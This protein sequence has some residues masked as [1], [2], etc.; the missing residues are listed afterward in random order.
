M[1]ILLAI[2]IGFILGAAAL[3]WGGG[4][5]GA[6]AGAILMHAWRS[7]RETRDAGEYSLPR[8]DTPPGAAAAVP[9]VR[10]TVEERLAAI[11][12]RLEALERGGVASA[13]SPAQASDR[14]PAAVPGIEPAGSPD[15]SALPAAAAAP[16]IAWSRPVAAPEPQFTRTPEGTLELA[17]A[18]AEARAPAATFASP[19]M[20]EFHASPPPAPPNPVWEWF[21]GGNVLTRIGVIAL[22]LGVG[23]LL[24]Y[25]ADFVT[26]PIEAKLAGVAL[27]GLGVMVLGARL[28]RTRPGYGVSLEGAGAGILYL[29]TFAALRMYDVLPPTAAFA[30]LLA[31]A[32]LTVW[33]ALRADSQPLAG[34]AIAGGFLAPFLVA[35]SSGQPA[36]LFGYF[37]VLNAAILVLALVKPWRE[38]NVLGFVFTFVLSLLWGYNYY[39][40]EHF[41]S[42]E[43]FL[44]AFFLFYV[45]I[46]VLYAKRGA[47]ETRA[48]VDA[49]LV[50]GVPLVALALQ[51]AL[52]HDM[53]YGIA[54]SAVAMSAVYAVMWLA[55]RRRAEPAFVLLSTA[56]LVLAVILATV[57]IPFAVDPRGTSAW[58]ALEAAGVYWIGCRQ[59]QPL[60]RGF[61][62]LLQLGAAAMFVY[63]VM[64]GLEEDLGTVF[65]N[66]RF[67]GSILIALAA[68]ATAFV[69]DRHR[70]DIGPAE[71]ALVPVILAWGTCWW[72]GAGVHELDRALP[73]ELA[74]N[75]ILAY[76]AGSVAAALAIRRAI[77]WPRLAWFGAGLLPVMALVALVDWHRSHTTLVA[78]GWL[79]W[80]LAW[81]LH[82]RLLRAAD[83]LR[84]ENPA[85]I[86]S[87]LRFAHAASAIA[88][89]AWLSWE[90]SEW[91]GRAFPPETVWVACAAAFP[92]I[93][94]LA[95]ATRLRTAAFWP[96]SEY[97]HAYSSRA[98]TFVAAL[99][100]V[101]FLIV[102]VISPGSPAP[103]PYI[104]LLNPL[105]LTLVAALAALFAWGKSTTRLSEEGLYVWFGLALFLLVNAIVFRVV[106]HWLGVPW[107]LPRLFASKPLQ[108]A[109]TLT[110]TVTALPLMVIANKR[111]VRPLWMAGA[112]LLAVVVVK[113]FIIDL[114]ALSGLTRIVAF[115][116]VGILLLLIG[117]LA[118]L[119]PA[120]ADARRDH[121]SFTP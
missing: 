34:L 30:L 117:Y 69:A 25:L 94:Y 55:L 82:W 3:G 44:V 99:L 26:V 2:V 96:F 16:S 31:I 106:H 86:D 93:A 39:R 51:S 120:K 15:T 87:L 119:P 111:S 63:G 118:P 24:S 48:P 65:L 102:N 32:A 68:L 37:L 77:G 98:G 79:V 92:A 88:L 116:G 100:A 11:E 20:E 70:A 54:W 27:A 83:A 91:V 71:H 21:T 114:S 107:S 121:G 75:A 43:P 47:L 33:L 81:A 110:W 35:T 1:M 72:Y 13:P 19:S 36:L 29:T 42:V 57:A 49:L 23:F 10:A 22:F 61:A 74:G 38:L 46:A 53:R 109:L 73:R 12:R 108:A 62:L 97:G 66:T 89:V 80:P 103:L 18:A 5:A 95:V 40:P 9:P 56:F 90:A 78:Y 28:A 52:V 115:L 112:A 58:W 85:R 8:F 6:F 104:P 14:P 45:A 76:V 7:R 41:A 105:D 50:F 101:W 17:A 113:L 59:R 67:M 60:A 64:N 4:L 84:D